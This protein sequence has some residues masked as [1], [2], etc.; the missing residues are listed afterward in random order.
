MAQSAMSAGLCSLRVGESMANKHTLRFSLNVGRLVKGQIVHSLRDTLF[1]EGF[2]YTI[3]E[4][5][6]LIEGT[7]Y[8]TVSDPSEERLSNLKARVEDWVQING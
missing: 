8:V 6:G 2:E 1:R 4:S 5:M 7:I 3:E